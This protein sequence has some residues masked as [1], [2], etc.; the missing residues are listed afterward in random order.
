M[1]LFE[2]VSDARIVGNMAPNV[3]TV[4]PWLTGEAPLHLV[5]DPRRKRRTAG[6]NTWKF[7]CDEYLN[8]G[9]DDEGDEG[10]G[11]DD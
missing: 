8:A 10:G 3:C 6:D 7:D 9:S 4:K 5:W 1:A 2:L 11:G